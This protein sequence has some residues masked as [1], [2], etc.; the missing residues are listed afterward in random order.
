[1]KRRRQG[2]AEEKMPLNSVH[3]AENGAT[4]QTPATLV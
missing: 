4:S 1:M 3:Y 2:S